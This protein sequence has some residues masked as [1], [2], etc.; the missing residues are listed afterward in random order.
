MSGESGHSPDSKQES[1]D[2]GFKFRQNG[3]VL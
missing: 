1:V 2:K 3:E